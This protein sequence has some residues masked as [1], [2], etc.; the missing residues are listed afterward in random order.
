MKNDD[1]LLQ[2]LGDLAR[3]EDPAQ[4]LRLD[5]LSAGTLCEDER[6]ALRARNVPMA[7][8]VIEAFRPIDEAGKERFV[9]AI[10]AQQTEPASTVVPLPSKRKWLAGTGVAGAVALAAAIALF[11]STRGPAP[12]P[13]YD[14]VVLGGE[15]G[16]RS[17]PAEGV[18]RLVA[19][20]RLELR[21]RP[22]TRT[23]GT[24]EVRGALKRGADVRT[25]SP[26]VH[27]D[28]DGAAR[29]VGTREEL[30]PGIPNGTWTVVV[31]IG[32]PDTLPTD[33]KTLFEWQAH[34]PV[35]TSLHHLNVQ[36]GP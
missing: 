26:P 30:F 14:L 33:P 12:L 29:I 20:S 16:V 31:G 17:K 18:P 6:E 22:A 21:L 32:R 3:D 27:Q 24:L 9:D 7:E 34:E 28:P 25:W 13:D 5:Q 15:S 11:V 36:L 10:L 2:A 8:D 35:G 4:D 23:S 1:D 19:G